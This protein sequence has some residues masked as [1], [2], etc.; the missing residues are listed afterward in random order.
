[1]ESGGGGSTT[2]GGVADAPAVSPA[3]GAAA[4]SSGVEEVIISQ[5]TVRVGWVGMRSGWAECWWGVVRVD[6]WID[7][8]GVAAHSHFIH[9][10]MIY[11]IDSS[12]PGVLTSSL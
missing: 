3:V 11:I 4:A 6:G 10:H 8:G 5:C 12:W 9:S 1:M 7:V 2:G